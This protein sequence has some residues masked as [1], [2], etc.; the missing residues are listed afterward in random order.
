LI[1]Q[2]EKCTTIYHLD[3][4]LLEPFGSKVRCSRCGHIFRVIPSPLSEIPRP[5]DFQQ[6]ADPLIPSDQ[7][8]QEEMEVLPV[9]PNR[10]VLWGIGALMVI[11]LMALTVRFFYL[12]HLHPR[13]SSQEILSAVF[14]LN[15]DPEGN[16]KISLINIKKYFKENKKMGRLFVVEGEVKNGYSDIR[17]RIRIR[18]SLRMSDDKI[19]TN[20]EIYAGWSF[21]PEELEDFS[22][23]DMNRMIVSQ[24]DR[25]P[26]GNRILPGRTLPFMIVFPLLP[27]GSN[28]VSIEVVGSQKASS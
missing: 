16:Q 10:R 24:P 28:Q 11:I 17:Q 7:D 14:F 1:I 5:K 15:T 9:V 12:Q 13:W 25:F 27:P 26:T 8:Q 20:R 23:D 22:Y 18:G 19:A 3:Q 21:S 4:A 6:I 2:C